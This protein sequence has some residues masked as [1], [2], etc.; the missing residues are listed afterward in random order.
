MAQPT[1]RRYSSVRPLRG[2]CL[3][4]QSRCLRVARVSRSVIVKTWGI[5]DWGDRLGGQAICHSA[6][7]NS[8]FRRR[9]GRALVGRRAGSKVVQ[10]REEPTRDVGGFRAGLQD[11]RNDQRAVW[12]GGVGPACAEHSAPFKAS[13]GRAAHAV[14]A[15]LAGDAGRVRERG[16]GRCFNELSSP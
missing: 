11:P 7:G 8:Q 6:V 5:G 16:I 3:A 13:T 1:R 14:A 4:I 15:P 12:E 10:D 9:R 2:D